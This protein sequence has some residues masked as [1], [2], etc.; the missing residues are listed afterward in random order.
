MKNYIKNTS[1]FMKKVSVVWISFTLL[2]IF[3]S[4]VF[5]NR[6]IGQIETEQLEQGVKE[7]SAAQA[8]YVDSIV[9]NIAANG[10]TLRI[11]L[12]DLAASGGQGLEEMSKDEAFFSYYFEKDLAKEIAFIERNKTMY[13]LKG[14]AG[15]DWVTAYWEPAFEGHI[16]VNSYLKT[17]DGQP[18]ILFAFP[19]RI[20]ESI[21]GIML[22]ACDLDYFS[23][24]IDIDSFNGQGF[25]HIIHC[26]NGDFVYTSKNRNNFADGIN[27]FDPLPGRVFMDGNSLDTLRDKILFGESFYVHYRIGDSQRVAYYRP[28]DV[29]DWYLITVTEK[30]A[31]KSQFDS[32]R[33]TGYI[34]IVVIMAVFGL[35]AAFII[36]LARSYSKDMEVAR[37][38]L[39]VENKKMR[40]AASQVAGLVFE[41]RP[42]ERGIEILS[43]NILN[44]GNS[45]TWWS[46]DELTSGVVFPG[47]LYIFNRFVQSLDSGTLMVSEDLRLKFDED[48][49]YNWYRAK[50]FRISADPDAPVIGTFQ[51]INY[52]KAIEA[53]QEKQKRYQNVLLKNSLSLYLINLTTN[54]LLICSNDGST[55]SLDEN[56]SFQEYFQAMSDK[57][58]HPED[59]AD[60]VSVFDRN[61]LIS[62]FEKDG[63]NETDFECRMRVDGE[64]HRVHCNMKFSND[65]YDGDTLMTVFINDI[66]DRKR[67]EEQWKQAAWHD[68]LT[69]LFN[70]KAAHEQ[71]KTYFSAAQEDSLHALFFIDADNFK[72]VNDTY[73]HDVGDKVLQMIGQ[74]LKNYFRASDFLCRWGG[75]EFLVL[76]RDARSE[77]AVEDRAREIVQAFAAARLEGYDDL[78]VSCSI[79]Y[80]IATSS[81]SDIDSIFKAADQALYMAKEKGKAC[82]CRGES[83]F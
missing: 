34:V 6:V 40:L 71:L 49:Y 19:I 36:K 65:A 15:E 33:T 41:Y 56:E 4:I 42:K 44:S 24:I 27:Y 82:Y 22:Y 3:L 45:K 70:K 83:N 17:K 54:R 25:G 9:E 77:E 32:K 68:E 47:D 20:G 12:E 1:T 61:H 14:L 64:Y 79:G 58:I 53:Q 73:G 38:H 59:K 18:V 11:R 46:L 23:R 60:F 21:Q 28:L 29:E 39:E 5:Y 69:G 8:R 78:R 66:E 2:C 80:V 50:L 57:V 67:E 35:L 16:V 31:F 10:Q 13:S 52:V 48:S 76:L 81:T 37:Q 55:I 63:K 75:D 30:T 43:E 51:D 62:E 74:M 26:T 7:L 72:Q